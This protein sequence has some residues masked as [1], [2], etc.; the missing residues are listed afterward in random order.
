MKSEGFNKNLIKTTIKDR[1]ESGGKAG[2]L[3]YMAAII[4]IVFVA[5]LIIYTATGDSRVKKHNISLEKKVMNICIQ[6]RWTRLLS[7]IMKLKLQK[8]R[9][10]HYLL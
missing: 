4:M 8:R 6:E 5:T 1:I 9:I 10:V 7:N 3:I 2:I